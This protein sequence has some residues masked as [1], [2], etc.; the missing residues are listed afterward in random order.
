MQARRVSRTSEIQPSPVYSDG[1]F[2]TDRPSNRPY[3][4]PCRLQL[5]PKGFEGQWEREKNIRHRFNFEN[6][7]GRSVLH[8]HRYFENW[9]RR[10]LPVNERHSPGHIVETSIV[11]A[12]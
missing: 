7:P 6:H 1:A 12:S 4:C 10:D 2:C 3:P 5:W 8:L 9:L 11:E